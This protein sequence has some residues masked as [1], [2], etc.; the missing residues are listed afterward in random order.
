MLAGRQ[1]LARA[2]SNLTLKDGPRAP[3]PSAASCLP[4]GP[5]HPR[6]PLPAPLP[7]FGGPPRTPARFQEADGLN[8]GLMP[9][10]GFLPFKEN[11]P[12]LPDSFPC[13]PQPPEGAR[14]LSRP[15]NLPL[16]PFR[17]PGAPTE[18]CVKEGV[19]QPPCPAGKGPRPPPGCRHGC[20]LW[21]HIHRTAALRFRVSCPQGPD[22]RTWD[23]PPPT[24]PN[25]ERPGT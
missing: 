19:A 2:L 10:L 18:R 24:H 7:G 13:P 15:V 5:W 14:P 25:P 21:T 22:T 12:Q 20:V 16:P 11:K 4:A 17:A 6:R 8:E 9:L 23:T 1:G 3:A